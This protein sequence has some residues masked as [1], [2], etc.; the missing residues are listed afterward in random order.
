MAMRI[1]NSGNKSRSTPYPTKSTSSQ[2]EHGLNSSEPVSSAA[3]GDV[4]ENVEDKNLEDKNLDDVKEE[5][6]GH[7]S[8]P[9]ISA[10]QP[11]A[12]RFNMTFLIIREYRPVGGGSGAW[13]NI[14]FSIDHKI[15][16]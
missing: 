6:G 5:T 10:R 12:G 14:A 13:E 15:R 8:Y 2:P 1:S 3:T 7:K 9:C 4:L 16:A 11:Y